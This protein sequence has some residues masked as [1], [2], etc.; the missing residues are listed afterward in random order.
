MCTHVI[1]YSRKYIQLM[2]CVI[3]SIINLPHPKYNNQNLHN[4]LRFMI[5]YF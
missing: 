3:R 1:P 2:S 5:H 4:K